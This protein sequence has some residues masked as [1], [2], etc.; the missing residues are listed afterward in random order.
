MRTGYIEAIGMFQLEIP[1]IMC[2]DLPWD[3]DA[4]PPT[5][6]P[7]REDTHDLSQ[8]VADVN[9]FVEKESQ[10]N[11]INVYDVLDALF[12]AYIPNNEVHAGEYLIG[13]LKPSV[14]VYAAWPNYNPVSIGGTFDSVDNGQDEVELAGVANNVRAGLDCKNVLAGLIFFTDMQT[15]RFQM[16]NFI[17]VRN[18]RTTYVEN[19]ET[20]FYSYFEPSDDA[21]LL[22]ECGDP[23]NGTPVLPTTTV[24]NGDCVYF[25]KGGN[26]AHRDG[27]PGGI[28]YPASALAWFYGIQVGIDYQ[29]DWLF[30]GGSEDTFL[31]YY[32][33]PNITTTTGPTAADGDDRQGVNW[34][35]IYVDVAPALGP[36]LIQGQAKPVRDYGWTPPL[37]AEGPND[38]LP[39]Y[40]VHQFND[41]YSLDDLE[42]ALQKADI[43]STYFTTKKGDDADITTN[44]DVVLT[45]STKHNH[46]FFAD[47]PLMWRWGGLPSS[48]DFD[49]FKYYIA[50]VNEY[51]GNLIDEDWWKG[52][53]HGLKDI[54][55]LLDIGY[56]TS[57]DLR[58]NK[59]DMTM[60]DWF[61]DRYENGPLYADSIIWDM[62]QRLA[63]DKWAANP[64][65]S[66]WAPTGV[67]FSIPHEV[68][69]VRVGAKGDH[70]FVGLG[71][72][73]HL[74][75][76][77]NKEDLLAGDFEPKYPWRKGHFRLSMTKTI[78]GQRSYDL[79]A[80]LLEIGITG[81]WDSIYASDSG[82]YFLPPIGVVIQSNESDAT[83]TACATIR[84]GMAEWHYLEL[85][86][87]SPYLDRPEL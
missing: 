83:G 30:A 81:D 63:T 15:G 72:A 9:L 86:N 19:W 46:W 85:L 75:E 52:D 64:P 74:L 55:E 60:S 12:F 71:A 27:Y 80:G 17:A 10:T 44:A 79:Y 66:P 67:T 78:N 43:W 11:I 50:N 3:P 82:D 18:F 48:T 65:P 42:I 57:Q 25:N 41:I 13:N 23:A 39:G 2:P 61:W 53:K 73:N 58:F 8:V 51:R 16:E 33:H 29:F 28:F 76:L 47:W 7:C 14:K 24:S 38:E 84:S 26:W 87:L 6:E 21:K 1:Q 5:G 36:Y 69:I 37:G 4:N 56:P 45:Y 62:N 31:W 68:N 70:T 34:N 54:E 22:G 32:I 40:F 35:D 77:A 59:D 20:P 49:D